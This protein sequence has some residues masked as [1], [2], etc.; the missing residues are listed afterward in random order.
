MA[1][2]ATVYARVEPEVKERAEAI[3]DEIGVPVSVVIGM[4]YRQI[5]RKNGIPLDLSLPV[6]RPKSIHEMTKEE[7]DAGM[8]QS[9]KDLDAGRYVTLEEM[10]AEFRTDDIKAI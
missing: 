8:E 7:F 10:E 1:K 5:I 2:T 9:F 6:E 4:L 3:L